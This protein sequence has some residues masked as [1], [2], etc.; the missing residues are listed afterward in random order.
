MFAE[1]NFARAK[2]GGYKHRGG[3]RVANQ[4]SLGH[5]YLVKVLQFLFG[6]GNDDFPIDDALGKG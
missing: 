1:G 4:D 3:K 6:F 2:K 5:A